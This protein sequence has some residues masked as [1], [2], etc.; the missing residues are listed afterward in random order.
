MTHRQPR[1]LAAL[2]V[3]VLAVAACSPGP[4]AGGTLEG[5]KWVLD[6]LGDDGALTIAPDNVYADAE[7]TAH[8]ISGFAGCNQFNGLYRS[9]GRT[10]FISDLA[11]TLMACDEEAMAFEQQY[12]A[13]LDQSRFYTSRRDTLTVYDGDFNAILRFDAAPRN[14]L[15]GTWVVDSIGDGAG[16]VTAPIEGSDLEV[17]FR[18]GT[19]GGFAG[20]N[21]FSG[22]YGTNGN[23]VWVSSLALT[24]MACDEELMA[25][26]LAFT[27]ALQGAAQIED[28][29]SQVNLTDRRGQLLLALVDPLSIAQPS[30]SPGASATPEP[31][32]EPTEEP[33]DEPTEEPTPKPT[34]EPTPEPTPEPTDEP[35][36]AP[37]DAPAPS[38]LPP[39]ATCDLE[40]ADGLTVATLVYP[41]AWFT[42]Q[43]PP[44]LACRFFDPVEIEVPDDGTPP[45]AAVTAEALAAPYLDAVADASDP[46]SWQ[47]LAQSEVEYRGVAIT[48]LLASAAADS[49]GV[50]VGTIRYQCFADV[51]AAGTVVIRTEAPPAASQGEAPTPEFQVQMAVVSLMT[52]ASTFN[53]PS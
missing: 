34:K 3:S 31:T 26:E 1:F 36:A 21:A 38:P 32:A 15:L 22:V 43:E 20:C 16:T 48:C 17:V 41:G 49:A 4:G 8:R 24:A 7:F 13:L 2:A 33:T 18:I 29:G 25:Q 9:G 35:T 46:E 53:P 44:E 51:G 5:T 28:R 40:S 50:A 45:A 42:V 27:T 47:V 23:A 19:V 52:F 37:T 10:L 14:P 6:S 30:A 12:L 39:T 11:T